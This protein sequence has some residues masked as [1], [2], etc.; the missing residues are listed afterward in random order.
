MLHSS[1]KRRRD[2]RETDIRLVEKEWKE[3]LQM[4]RAEIA[5]QHMGNIT[6]EQIFTLQP[7]EDT[8]QVD[9]SW[10]KPQPRE[11]SPHSSRFL[12]EAAAPG[13]TTP[14]YQSLPKGLYPT[15]THVLKR[16]Y[17]VGR[18]YAER[19]EWESCKEELLQTNHNSYLYGENPNLSFK[20]RF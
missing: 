15:E 20:V 17:P 7:V 16:L 4:P 8:T 19:G 2:V 3:V 13:R 5:L 11:S 10:I 18:A 9:M 12:A 14:L 1:C 6:V